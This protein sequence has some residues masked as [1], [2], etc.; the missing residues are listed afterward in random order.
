[1]GAS[2]Q[3][4]GRKID[5]LRQHRGWHRYPQHGRQGGDG[6]TQQRCMRCQTAIAAQIQGVAMFAA[7]SAA[8]AIEVAAADTADFLPCR[9]FAAA[10][11]SLQCR[12]CRHAR[13][14]PDGQD[15]QPD[16]QGMTTTGHENNG[17]RLER[18]VFYGR[19]YRITRKSAASGCDILSQPGRAQGIRR[20]CAWHPVPGRCR[21]CQ[22]DR[23]PLAAHS[24]PGHRSFAATNAP[25]WNRR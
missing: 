12:C 25:R 3:W 2:M 5:I 6:R 13:A 14:Q 22:T 8:G 7:V 17:H 20:I 24:A 19:D 15:A 1:M 18:S 10:D 16:E 11:G 23:L 4:T 9:R 21:Y